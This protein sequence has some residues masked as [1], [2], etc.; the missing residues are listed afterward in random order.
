MNASSLPW[1]VLSSSVSLGLLTEGWPLAEVAEGEG[2]DEQGRSF[3]WYVEFASIFVSPPVIQL[4]LTGFD[5]DDRDSARLTVR[6]ENISV[7]GFDLVIGT[8]ASTRVYGV[9]AQ[10]LAIGS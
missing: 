3:R 10:W 9:E 2:A 4:G 7:Y 6:A 5:I 1:Q 8:W